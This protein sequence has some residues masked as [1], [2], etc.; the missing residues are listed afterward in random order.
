M[1][2]EIQGGK[3]HG[4]DQ[5]H[6]ERLP[7]FPQILLSIPC[8]PTPLVRIYWS[9][10]GHWIEADPI[11]FSVHLKYRMERHKRGS[12][13]STIPQSQLLQSLALPWASRSHG[14]F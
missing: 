14:I 9:R 13:W 12:R 1:K 4:M 2:P 3:I 5:Y 7:H 11:I 6:L 8:G 10:G